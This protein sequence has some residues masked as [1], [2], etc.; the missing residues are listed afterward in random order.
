VGDCGAFPLPATQASCLRRIGSRL[1]RSGRGL[2]DLPDSEVA[3][4]GKEPRSP[5]H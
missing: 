3:G 5:Y 2:R 1:L 4:K